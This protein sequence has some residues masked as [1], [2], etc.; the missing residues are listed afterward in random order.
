M[1]AVCTYT[2]VLFHP[3]AVGYPA[4]INPLALTVIQT[5]SVFMENVALHGGSF[6]GHIKEMCKTGPECLL[7]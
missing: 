2:R 4:C 1:N 6:D 7:G 3:A 5:L